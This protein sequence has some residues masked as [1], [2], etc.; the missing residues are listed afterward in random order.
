[1]QIVDDEGMGMARAATPPALQPVW[2]DFGEACVAVLYDLRVRNRPDQ[3]CDEECAA[4]NPGEYQECRVRPQRG[5]EPSGER[6]GYEPAGVRERELRREER[7]P[8]FRVRGAAQQPA[9]RSL[10]R[11]E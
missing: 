1:M 5:T 4:S 6:I 9:R 3:N 8:V 10:R 7:R 11:A 2:I